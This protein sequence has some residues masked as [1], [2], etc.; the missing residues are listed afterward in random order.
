MLAQGPFRREYRS[1]L[2]VDVVAVTDHVRHVHF[3]FHIFLVHAAAVAVVYG[4]DSFAETKTNSHV[5]TMHSVSAENV[6]TFRSLAAN[7][8]TFHNTTINVVSSP[9][10][11]GGH[12][13]LT[14][15]RFRVAQ[16]LPVSLS[17]IFPVERFERR[18]E[19][20]WNLDNVL[21]RSK[22]MASFYCYHFGFFSSLRGMKWQ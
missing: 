15:K 6:F 9:F 20:R 21:M 4:S 7:K 10:D 17:H 1:M 16:S 8:F 19:L 3:T 14:K 12:N 22:N 13:D 11:T 5:N 2:M 18:R